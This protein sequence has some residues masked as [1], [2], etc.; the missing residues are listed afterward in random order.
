MKAKK[1]PKIFLEHILES[2]NE[3][4]KNI[5]GMSE[6][7]FS[8][9]IMVQDAVARR[10]E[11]IGEAVRNIPESFRKKYPKVPWKK[12]AGLRDVLIHEYFGVDMELVW[13]IANKDIPKLKNQ[14][15]NILEEFE[16]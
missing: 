6:V 10:L 12:I 7:E 5:L 13:K 2:I 4:E 16:K 8:Q 1:D 14:V 3:I 11:I 9:I 15:A